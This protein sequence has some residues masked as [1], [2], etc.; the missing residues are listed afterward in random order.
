M[1]LLHHIP[2]PRHLWSSLCKFSS[3]IHVLYHYIDLIVLLCGVQS[4]FNEF[5]TWN[6]W[7]SS[8]KKLLRDRGAIDIHG[9]LRVVGL[10]DYC[11]D[12]RHVFR[13]WSGCLKYRL[14]SFSIDVDGPLR[15]ANWCVNHC[16]K[17]YWRGKSST[18]SDGCNYGGCIPGAHHNA[19]L[20]ICKLHAQRY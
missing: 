5:K 16:W 14:E 17:L 12:V 11:I 1:L 19:G 15:I 4:S 7:Q 6:I 10:W 18:S 2:W 9:L 13:N 8:H 20:Q 3:C